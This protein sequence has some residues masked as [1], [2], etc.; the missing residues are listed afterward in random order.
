MNYYSDIAGY[1]FVSRSRKLGKGGGVGVYVL[2]G[3]IWERRL[4]LKNEEVLWIEIRPKCSK[5][6]LIASVYRPPD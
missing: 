2:D 3:L 1:S 6:I 5:R 4:D